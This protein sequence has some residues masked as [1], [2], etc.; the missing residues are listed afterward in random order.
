[1]GQICNGIVDCP[2]GEDE[3]NCSTFECR[4]LNKTKCPFEEK[5]IEDRFKC[6]D[7]YTGNSEIQCKLR[8]DCVVK[9]LEQDE[10]R[11]FCPHS[12]SSRSKAQW[13]KDNCPKKNQMC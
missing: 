12:S 4:K 11:F 7:F 6:N 8:G 3:T 13:M 10:T 9:C 1:M 5:C 2:N